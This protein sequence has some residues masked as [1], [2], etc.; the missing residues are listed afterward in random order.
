MVLWSMPRSGTSHLSIELG[1]H[2]CI[3][4]A[5][6][7]LHP[8]F[9]ELHDPL[10][11]SKRLSEVMNVS[12]TKLLL[13]LNTPRSDLTDFLFRARQLVCPEKLSLPGGD[14]C[15]GRC[16]LAVKLFDLW[17]TSA[18]QPG[19]AKLVQHEDVSTVVL[20]RDVM[21]MFC[22]LKHAR[23]H[24]DWSA[25]PS[26]HKFPLPNCS[27]VAT[28]HEIELKAR[29]ADQERWHKLAASLLW[30]RDYLSIPFESTINFSTFSSVYAHI[31]GFL[32][33]APMSQGMELPLDVG[34]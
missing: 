20:Y 13:N 10:N 9:D 16:V 7:V 1:K 18:Y 6:E 11:I 4:N 31:I 23:A 2:P 24:R 5:A 15:R 8:H 21:P 28:E 32:G 29:Q 26:L 22:S 25:V 3:A 19:L 17:G 30:Q 14:A 27:D 34:E 12:L 33:L